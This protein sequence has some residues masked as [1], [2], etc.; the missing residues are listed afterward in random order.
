MEF[1]FEAEE[2]PRLSRRAVEVVE[3]KGMGHPDTI[4]DALAEEV[5]LALCK[6]YLDRF[7]TI[8]HHNV[9]KVLL[10]GGQSQPELGGGKVVTPIELYLAGRATAEV[11]GIKVPVE[12]LAMEACTSWLRANLR[13]LDVDAHVR[14]HSRI[15][16]GSQDLVELF[17]REQQ[18][19]EGEWLANDTSCGV[20]FAPLTP[21]ESTV[22]ETERAL[23]EPTALSAHPERGEDIKVMAVRHGSHVRLTVSDAFVDRHVLSLDDYRDKRAQL[24]R[25]VQALS[26]A[27]EVEVNAADDLE[28]GSV[29]LTVTGTSAESGDDGEAGRGN[30]VCGLITPYRPMTME[31]AAGKNPVTH[32]G[33]IYN[34][35]AREIAEA[36]VA[37]IEGVRGAECYLVSRIGRPV[38]DPELVH[39]RIWLGLG[40]SLSGV[41]AL[42]SRIARE[43]LDR[44]SDIR[45]DVLARRALVL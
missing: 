33:K 15:R 39:V 36:I 42:V 23:R 3:R 10:V 43:R 31:S 28:R 30:R 6:F 41:E 18:A 14:L 38:K 19:A 12:E 45:Q 8:L 1:I 21:L 11:R 37:E 40:R 29:Y 9:D 34:I 27:D 17:L 26:R 32:V 16:P 4:C 13:H 35:V 2:S 20:G 5:S 7:G 25:D 44:V 22:L 24:V